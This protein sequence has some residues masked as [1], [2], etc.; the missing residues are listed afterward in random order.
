[1]KLGLH[2]ISYSGSWGQEKLD[3]S[4]FIQHAARL[5]YGCVLLAGKRPQLSTL[6]TDEERVAEV[7]SNLQASGMTC[8][9]IAAYNDFGARVSADVPFLEMQIAHLESLCRL[10]A[11]LGARYIRVFTAYLA[12]GQDFHTTWQRTVAALREVSERAAHY[13]MIVAVQNH[14]DL[15]V[16]TSVLLE[17][18]GDIDRPNCKLAFDAWS[19]ALR[20]EDLYEAA[21]L[22]AP[23]TVITTN[24][25]YVAL[26]RYQYHPELINYEPKLPAY[27][28]AVP[29]GTG[30]I[31]Y[32]AFFRGLRE[33]GFDGLASYEMCSPLRGGGSLEHLDH[34]ART[35]L[36]WMKQHGFA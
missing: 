18:L 16:D 6:D 4:Q 28:R 33:G 21:K 30:A 12:E 20:G 11:R 27:M 1:M 9:A 35:Y 17:L 8:G 34:C 24:A 13:K 23:H 19:P 14:H 26:P 29:F 3:L 5:G 22:A 7:A 32:D 36:V 25:D 10:G 2:S 15:A 31:D